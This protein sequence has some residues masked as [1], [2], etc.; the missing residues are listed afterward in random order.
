M[1][2]DW[3]LFNEDNEVITSGNSIPDGLGEMFRDDLPVEDLS[4]DELEERVNKSL[5]SD[6][7]DPG[8]DAM[9]KQL[10][11]ASCA[12]TA[13][14]L[15]RG[16]PEPPY[17]GKFMIGDH[18]MEWDELISK[19][20]R[21]CILAA[22][23]HGKCQTG[24][25]P[26]LKSD[27]SS[28]R[29]DE[30]KGGEL[31]VWDEIGRNF[32]NT[33]VP[34]SKRNGIKPVYRIKTR[35]GRELKLTEE[36]PLLKWFG[37]TR[38]SDLVAGDRIAVARDLSGIGQEDVKDSW[39]LGAL[40][41]DGG[42]TGSNVSITKK[43][44]LFIEEVEK[45]IAHRGWELSRCSNKITYNIVRSQPRK[46]E[47]AQNW[48][49]YHGIMGKKSTEKTVP[50]TIFRARDEDIADFL[51]GY[52]DSDGGVGWCTI[53]YYS[54]SKE[55]L[56]G[57][58][59]LLTR[60]GVI[61]RLNHK[62]GKYKGK[63]HLSWRL[64]VGSEYIL[65]FDD[66]ICLRSKKA[67]QLQVLVDRQKGLTR[68]SGKGI[69]LFPKEVWSEF[70]RSSFWHQKNG[71]NRINRQCSPTRSKVQ[72][73]CEQENNDYVQKWLDAP[74]FW[75]E[76]KEIE[77]LEPEE[78]WALKVPRYHTYISNDIINHNTYFIDFAYPIWQ[79]VNN[80]RKS[81]FIFSSTQDQAERILGDIREEIETNPKLQWLIPN[82]KEK[83]GSRM[84]RC[85]N[86]H[87]VYARG[88]G[89]KVR[90]AH[91]QWICVDDG[92]T[93][94]T[95]YSEVVRRK[96]IDYFRAAITNMITPGGQIIVVGTP[97]HQSDLYA[98]LKD[99][100]E[101][102]YCE[103]PAESHPGHPDNKALWPDRYDLAY[104]ARR[105]REI[106]SIM[107]TREF[108][109]SPVSDEM[110]L[111]PSYLFQGDDVERFNIKLGMPLEFWQEAGITA[112]MGV[113]FAMSS[114]VSADYTVV[115]VLG[116]D[117]YG[118]RWII[119]IQREHGM[120]YQQQLSVINSVAR[121]YEPAL[122]F[123]EDN[124]MQRIFGDELIRTSD[125]PIKKFTTGVQKNS[126]DK[127]VP[128]LRVLLEN[129]K[130]RIPRGDAHSVK[131][132]DLWKDEMRSFTWVDGKLTSVGEHDDMAMAFWVADQAVR[133][134]GVSF[135]F[136]DEEE[137]S[138]ESMDDLM[139]ELMGESSG[140][141]QDETEAERTVS[142]V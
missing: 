35:T 49:R 102:H 74:V 42:L 110:S 84:I 46:C 13:Q 66:K 25:S 2:D 44:P 121:K 139:A 18:H 94:E 37:W 12:F 1:N 39:L 31:L 26:L 104:L 19:H 101:Y 4:M 123:L 72:R 86:G 83:W 99:N 118:N 138:A 130:I 103:Y 20:K 62:K 129:K 54:T 29:I 97:L 122:V 78:T 96:Q 92:L 3:T 119:D 131:M 70:I 114:N 100:P 59:H 52:F 73:M 76:I 125:L 43:D 45:C 95:Q 23:D 87:R 71:R 65:R 116:V 14:E 107:Y 30:W 98:V 36:H 137:Y 6:A 141:T 79:I 38:A 117:K 16:P 7:P 134:G 132:T 81:G 90:G 75:D 124:Q 136:G 57:V 115:F 93:D 55:L 91:P 126:L 105:K 61:S 63:P 85:S 40:V 22:R 32:A 9:T 80:P 41:G 108:L 33:Y 67:T 88:F 27:G 113:D 135:S 140:D 51:A 106:G 133:Q 77:K 10:I 60:L 111:F 53:E 50:E 56:E 127:G 58:Q 34:A 48:A 17:N 28:V 89:T 11:K 128:S 69:D 21:L 5:S 82:I 120:A 64:V 109:C 112:F 15:L 8:W 68:S 24:E 47:P 142:L